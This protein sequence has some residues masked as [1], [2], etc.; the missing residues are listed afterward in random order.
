MRHLQ[1]LAYFFLVLFAS[2]AFA[3][4]STADQVT[5]T[6]FVF[7]KGGS[8][9]RGDW[10]GTGRENERPLHRVEIEDFYL[11][12]HE[13]T[14][15]QYRRFADETGYRTS[16]E[17]RGWVIDIG[18]DMSRWEQRQGVHWRNPGF[19]QTGSHPVVWVDWNDATAFAK[20]LA[21][22]T[23]KPYRLPTEAEWEYAARSEGKSE[24]WAGST[25]V[26]SLPR[27]AWYA[28]N[29]DGVTHPVGE[30]LPNGLGLYDMSGNV[31][32]WC[33]DDLAAYPT[34]PR[35]SRDGGSRGSR[36]LK[37]GSW[38]VPPEILT[39]TYRS[40]YKTGYSH[41][42]MGFRLALDAVP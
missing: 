22:K 31:W 7:V 34:R 40:A 12:A 16:A 21:E 17:V 36:V 33:Q 35:P 25:R 41:S 5:G 26:D 38:R 30:K 11:A 37:G 9:A 23:G 10:T 4:D 27:Y 2:T 3:G 39:T 15:D 28:A 32:E 14:V 19:P 24:R 18:A 13:V 8:Y 20:W 42:S 1:Q 29:S 6:Q